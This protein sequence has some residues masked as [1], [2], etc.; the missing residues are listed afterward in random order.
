MR[1]TVKNWGTKQCPA[2]TLNLV[3]ES[4]SVCTGVAFEFS[5][6]SRETVTSYLNKREGKN[7]ELEKV[8]IQL[9][10]GGMVSARTSMYGGANLIRGKSLSERAEMA[11]Q[12]RG[13]SGCCIDYVDGIYDHLVKLG[14]DD[15]SVA[16]FRNLVKSDIQS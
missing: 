8:Q 6:D 3:K 7:F 9:H 14:I 13:I 12:A 10:D 5:D 4:S 11:R 1:Y 2:P 16:E 15:A